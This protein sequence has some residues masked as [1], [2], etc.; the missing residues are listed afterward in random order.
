MLASLVLEIFSHFIQQNEFELLN[1][2]AV[3]LI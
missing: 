2:V 3:I 1:K